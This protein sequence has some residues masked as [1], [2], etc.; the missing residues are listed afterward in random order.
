M[1]GSGLVFRPSSSSLSSFT[2]EGYRS[3]V[4]IYIYIY[5][6]LC[7]Y[8]SIYLSVLRQVAVAGVVVIVG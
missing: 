5:I 7:V 3:G 2:D 8:M 4:S 1:Q 6:Y